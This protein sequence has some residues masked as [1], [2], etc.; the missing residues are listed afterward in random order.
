[1]DEAKKFVQWL[2]LRQNQLEEDWAVNYG[3]HVPG[4]ATVAASAAK[5]STGPVKEAVQLGHADGKSFPG[6][7]N[8]ACQTAFG[9][10]T[11]QLAQNGGDAQRLLQSAAATCQAEFAK[12][13]G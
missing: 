10:A 7:W 9:T 3:F 12:Q 13:L 2:W 5:L 11:T 6:L 1:M 4:R 8:T